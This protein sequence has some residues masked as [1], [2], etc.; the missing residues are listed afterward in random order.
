MA[1]GALKKIFWPRPEINKTGVRIV[2]FYDKLFLFEKIV[3]FLHG[4]SVLIEE[5]V[6]TVAL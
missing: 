1:V 2:E 3:V 6:A 5:D 4:F